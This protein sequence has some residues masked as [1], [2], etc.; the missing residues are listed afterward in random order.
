MEENPFVV[1]KFLPTNKDPDTYFD[2]GLRKWI[3]TDLDDEMCGKTYWP[4]NSNSVTQLVKTE[5]SFKTNWPKHDVEVKRF[6]NTYPKARAA[7]SGFLADSNY[8]TEIE[9]YMGRGKRRKKSRQI[10]SSDSD[11]NS[12]VSLKLTTKIIPAPPPVFLK[13]AFSNTQHCDSDSNSN[14]SSKLMK[15]NVSASSTIKLSEVEKL[16][17]EKF[18]ETNVNKRVKTKRPFSKHSNVNLTGKEIQIAKEIAASKMKRP[19]LLTSLSKTIKSPLKP[20]SSSVSISSPTS[21]NSLFTNSPANSDTSAVQEEENLFSNVQSPMQNT[22]PE[23]NLFIHPTSTQDSI[24]TD[25][26]NRNSKNISSDSNCEHSSKLSNSSTSH[27]TYGR[28]TFKEQLH[29]KNKEETL[30]LFKTKLDRTLVIVEEVSGKLDILNMN[31][32]KLMRVIIPSEKRISRPEKMPAL[33]LNTKQDLEEFNKFL[34]ADHNL[35]AACHY[36]SNYMKLSVKNPE[37]KSATNMLTKLL[38]NTLASEINCDGGNGKI[39]FKSLKLYDLFQGTLQIAFSN[40]DL[41][42]ANAA[43]AGWLKDAKWRK[44]CDGSLGNRKKKS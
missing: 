19:E 23:D 11:S 8:K 42:E 28:T 5:E 39:A 40:S 3:C 34:E 10:T 2:V 22:I 25:N 32:S 30:S 24:T 21:F 27:R 9:Q 29:N 18:E 6:Y 33:P 12:N 44:Q 16:Q 15:R 17:E 36:M 20:V 31:M 43:L 41:T 26:F 37:R 38:S 13:K 1:L 4:P 14:T 7:I 35:A